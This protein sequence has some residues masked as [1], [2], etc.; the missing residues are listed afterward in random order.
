MADRTHPTR[1]ALLDAG[2]ALVDDTALSVL[3]I[4][5]VVRHAGVAKGTFYVHFTDRVEY[6]VE[7]HRS[8]HAQ[9]RTAIAGSVA[10][11]EPGADRLR[12]GTIAYLDGCLQAHGVKAMLVQARGLPEIGREVATSN[13]RFALAVRP[14]LEA[15]GA[16]YPLEAARLFVAM[17]AE[18]ALQEL[19]VRRRLPRLRATLSAFAGIER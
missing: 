19:E 3:S 13:R 15:L 11:R 18:T 6:L 7:M 9:L 17:A 12:L 16:P 1:A 5:E 14:D 4:D 2:F 8:F 10:G